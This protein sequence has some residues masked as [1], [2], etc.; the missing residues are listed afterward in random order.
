MARLQAES[1]NSNASAATYGQLIAQ[2]PD[3]SKDSE[4]LAALRLPAAPAPQALTLLYVEQLTKLARWA[5]IARILSVQEEAGT[6]NSPLRYEFARAL[7]RTGT[8]KDKS[9]STKLL[10]GL[11]EGAPE[12][13]WKNLAREALNQ[14]E[15]NAKEGRRQ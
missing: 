14:P 2:K 7:S 10:Q 1:G 8:A 15:V 4:R 3:E 9:K 6:L 13:F 11:A 5:E 12:E